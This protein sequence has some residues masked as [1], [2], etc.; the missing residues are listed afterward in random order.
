VALNTDFLLGKKRRE[1]YPHSSALS[2]KTDYPEFFVITLFICEYLL[3]LEFSN[4][5]HPQK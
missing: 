1:D 5:P 3:N 2:C 4:L